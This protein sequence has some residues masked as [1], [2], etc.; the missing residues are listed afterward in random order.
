MPSQ[1]RARFGQSPRSGSPLASPPGTAATPWLFWCLGGAPRL[2]QK[3]GQ[4]S[5]LLGGGRVSLCG[6]FASRIAGQ[7]LLE[8]PRLNAKIRGQQ[9]G[10]H[11]L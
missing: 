5:W 11:R 10:K 8:D 4:G 1:P 2:R 9:P 6:S 3:R 7:R